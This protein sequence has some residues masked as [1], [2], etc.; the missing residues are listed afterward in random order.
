M[1]GSSRGARWVWT[2]EPEVLGLPHKQSV[3]VRKTH[4]AFFE[5]PRK[6]GSCR[7]VARYR[8]LRLSRGVCSLC[9]VLFAFLGSR[10]LR[11]RSAPKQTAHT[12]TLAFGRRPTSTRQTEGRRAAS[13]HKRVGGWRGLAGK[14]GMGEGGGVCLPGVGRG[15][16]QAAGT[17]DGGSTRN[18]G[19]T[20]P[21]GQ[22]QAAT[23]VAVDRAQRGWGRGE[24]LTS[25]G[26]A[27]AAR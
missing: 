24:A 9:A 7:G 10:G 14:A 23:A 25:R 22:R 1:D 3:W 17:H 18:G 5:N 13:P 19:N 2:T 4:S 8:R 21:N 15:A 26:A 16:S 6:P 12:R 11:A 20:A 27:G